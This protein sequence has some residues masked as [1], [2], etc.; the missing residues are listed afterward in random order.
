MEPPPFI[1]QACGRTLD[2]QRT[3]TWIS[4]RLALLALRTIG[5]LAVLFTV[6]IATGSS[7][8]EAPPRNPHLANSSYPIGHASSAQQTS[9]DVAVPRDET[10]V[11]DESEIDY[12]HLGPFH[13][14]AHIS[15]RYADGRRVIWSN[16]VDRVA[17]VDHDSFEVLATHP[18]PGRTS[19]EPDDATAYVERFNELGPGYWSVFQALQH[20][21]S[22]Y[23]DI[24]GIYTLV[25]GKGEYYVCGRREITVY[26]DAEPGNPDSAIEVRRRFAWPDDV[27]GISVGMN[28]SFDGRVLVA[29]EDG[30]LLSLARDFSSMEVVRLRFSE[31][32]SAAKDTGQGW[33]RNGM[34]VDHKGGIYLVS[35]DH[36]HKVVWTGTR[37]SQEES[38]GT[39]VSPYRN[40][41]GGGSGSTPSL[42]GFGEEDRFVVITDG[43]EVMNLTLFWRDEIPDGWEALPGAPSARIAGFAPVTMG[44]DDVVASQTEQSVVVGGY[45]ALVVNNEPRNLP[46][47]TGGFVVPVSG[48]LGHIPEYQP[49]GVQK[50]EWNPGARTLE[51]AW[52]NHEVSSPNAVP[53]LSIPSNLVFT[54]G[55]RGG[56]WTMEAI[57]WENGSSAYHL[58]V[59]DQRYNSAY[60]A[61]EVD[62]AGRLLWGT[63]WGRARVTPRRA[64]D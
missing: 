45:G 27:T 1:A 38:D 29:T 32:A 6:A 44:R 40:G 25:D 20:A 59:G 2:M 13:L 9:Q 46:W 56:S 10:R 24:S 4:G 28:M 62:E 14:G 53:I 48:F 37:F 55:A 33:I 3:L 35:R 60:A 22:V 26:G 43:D 16:G 50:F 61:V 54:V 23:T 39:W 34:A 57:D 51:V 47:G 21:R 41:G 42:M 18:L 11:L 8:A 19:F 49:F 63:V 31:E 58:V 36:V 5:L 17:K 64:D 52:V 7:A 12:T 30:F 15:P